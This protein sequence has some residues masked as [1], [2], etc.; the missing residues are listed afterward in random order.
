MILHLQ[1]AGDALTLR[2]ESF[3]KRADAV[4]L[5]RALAPL[6]RGWQAVVLEERGVLQVLSVL[7]GGQS[8][9]GLVLGATLKEALAL[10]PLLLRTITAGRIAPRYL[11]ARQE[12]RWRATVLP[13]GADAELFNALVDTW[14]RTCASTPLSRAQGRKGAFHT[15]EDAWLAALRSP[16]A[17]MPLNDPALAKQLDAWASPLY[18]GD[19]AAFTFTPRRTPEGWWLDFA[20]DSPETLGALRV[21]GQA[22]GVSPRLGLPQPWSDADFL[23]F[24]REGVPALRSAAFTV[25]LP[26]ELEA[27]VPQV[28]ETA[29]ALEADAV[30][31]VRTVC[32]AGVELPIAEAQAIL[33]AGE[34]LVYV[35]GAWRYVDLEALRRALAS[36]GEELVPQRQ[37]LPLL[38]AGVV[39]IAPQAQAVQDFLREMT[40]PPAGEL[41]L[42]DV[43]RPYQAQGVCWLMHAS[44]HALGVCLADDMG[45]GKTLQAI[46][47]L[48]SRRAPALVVAPMTVLPVW[49]R[50]LARWAPEL[51]VLKHEGANRLSG[52]GFAKRA[53]GA[54]VT[55]TSYGLLW[56]DYASFRRV[57]WETLILDEAQ[58]IK[59]PATRQA[60]AARSLD[61]SFR[62]ALTGT[63]IENRLADLWS[64]LDFLNPN[65][66]G[67]R[68]DFCERYNDPDRL[69]RAV[70]H[71]ILRRLKSD[72]AILSEL[73]PKIQQEHY[74]PLTARQGAAY[75]LALATFARESRA[76][77][78]GE[79]TGAALAL[80]THLK[81]ICDGITGPSASPLAV[82]GADFPPADASG[83][84]L[85][86]LPL[87]DSIFERGESALIFTQF[88]R[89]GAWVHALLEEK[90]GRPVAFL[91]G[92]QSAT[93]RRAEIARF[94]EDPRPAPFVLS[95]RTGAFGLTLTKANHVIHL[96]RW[97][98]PA[99][100][101][102]ATDRA[103][104]IGQRRTVVV[105]HIL[106]RGTVEDAIDRLLHDKRELAERIVAPTPA[107][108]LARLPADTLTHLLHRHPTP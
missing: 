18:E 106:C 10:Y 71:F 53:S 56:R 32:F 94:N 81:E 7:H 62:L 92:A 85:V 103:H 58:Q 89:M 101:N 42:R 6:F 75:D 4:A 3:G 40:T 16:S 83:K 105:H 17:K 46:A 59:N 77:V 63:P 104:R 97:W 86:L 93:A 64:I 72:P 78:S 51:T 36:A 95:L 38:L 34:E 31:V 57:R 55:L 69:R 41:P 45:L 61:A 13:V 84:L 11:F 47:F 67:T 5:R 73:P 79:R 9:P 33:D 66:F 52:A 14:M 29:V 102:Q 80:L 21:L 108:Q 35:Q 60:Q 88:V 25:A 65:L 49:E 90:L 23:A 74:A 98:N 30:R 76:R 28:V 48:A 107:A 26:A 15:V 20:S 24:L 82:P 50:E 37:A 22:V 96:D 39:R 54:A 2:G 19:R 12:A 44:A 99:V 87:L 43:L 27:S 70:S 68:R 1:R 8:V 100:E 91:H